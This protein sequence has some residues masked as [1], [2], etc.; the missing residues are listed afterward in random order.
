MKKTTQQLF[1][2]LCLF[3]CISKGNAQESAVANPQ[4]TLNILDEVLF[5]D[6]YAA[7]VSAP[8]P[9]GVIRHRNDLYATKLSATVLSSIGASLTMNIT[10]KA[11][12]DNY[13]R[14]G[15]VNLA[16]VPK[17]ATTYNPA[18]VSRI[19]VGRFITPFMNKNVQPDQVPY[20]FAVNNVAKILRDPYLN[21]IYDFWVELQVFGVPYAA[22]EQI[23]GC[24]GRNDVFFGSLDFVTAGTPIGSAATF[25]LPLSMI[26]D[27]NNY[28]PNAT[29]AV[30]TTA[31]TISFN[32][33]NAVPNAKM[34]L[35]TSNHGSND[36]GEEYVRRIHNTF[37]DNVPNI[38]YTPGGI[39]CEPFRMYNTQGNGI[40]GSSPQTTSWW[41]EWNNWCPGNEIPIRVLTLGTLAAGNHTFKITVPDAQFVGGQ[42]NFPLSLYLQGD[43]QSQLQVANFE[44]D[45]FRL[46]PNPTTGTAT[47]S[48]TENVRQVTVNNMMGQKVWTGNTGE[49]DLSGLAPNVYI[50]NIEFENGQKT[51]QKIVKK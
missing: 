19:E 31:K 14:I 32:L 36:G 13:D 46:Y 2:L 24:A 43:G 5:Y 47:V 1:S 33:V 12:C 40:Y 35:I 45:Q 25:L 44:R 39:S 3:I 6:G 18:D 29:D 42:G 10:I 27:F 17:G 7:P 37:V 38:T 20:S 51:V 9:D 8:V 22:Q 34:Y 23:A 21:S 4:V 16:F 41:T 11:S 48:Y 30:G 15:N 26:A 49:I 50:V 28:N